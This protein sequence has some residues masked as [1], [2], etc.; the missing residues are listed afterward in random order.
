MKKSLLAAVAVSSALFAQNVQVIE[1]SRVIKIDG[2]GGNPM[3]VESLAG[4]NMSF[5]AKTVKGKPYSAESITESVQTLGDGTRIARNNASRT[6]RDSEGRVR[7]E[8]DLQTFGPNSP[9]TGKKLITISDP[10]GGHE[11]ILDSD[12]KIARK[13]AV[14]AMS[15]SVK[16]AL[17]KHNVT[18]SGNVSSSNARV[19]VFERSQMITEEVKG[20]G[21][22]NVTIQ[23]SGPMPGLGESPMAFNFN[24]DAN[25]DVKVEDLGTKTINGVACKGSKTTS[26]IPTGKIGNDRPIVSTRESWY[27][28]EIE[29]TIMYKTVDPRFGETTFMLRGIQKAEPATELF[30]AP[31]DYKVEDSGRQT[32]VHRIEKK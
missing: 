30:Q 23:S 5:N 25:A 11:W 27:S 24:R 2:R 19:M 6:Y 17:K 29:A 21:A 14:P 10:V 18:G 15:D 32:W 16:E 13:I 9:A 12:N 28:D 22:A 26:T 4:G 8:M 7:K 1:G 31:A 20:A 3:I